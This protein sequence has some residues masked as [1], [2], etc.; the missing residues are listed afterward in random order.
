MSLVVSAPQPCAEPGHKCFFV[1]YIIA[2]ACYCS[3]VTNVALWPHEKN[4]APSCVVWNYS[5]KLL[6]D[7]G[8]N[9]LAVFKS[10]CEHLLCNETRADAIQVP[11]RLDTLKKFHFSLQLLKVSRRGCGYCGNTEWKEHCF[12]II[13]GKQATHQPGVFTFHCE[14]RGKFVMC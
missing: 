14:V 2:F 11:L 10:R 3:S 13:T 8:L 4:P 6:L 5:W 12:L 7:W 1:L 9:F